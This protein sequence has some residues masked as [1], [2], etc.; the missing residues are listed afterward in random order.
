MREKLQAQVEQLSREAEEKKRIEAENLKL[1]ED[2]A[3][4]ANEKQA[5]LAEVM[6]LRSLSI[7][8]STQLSGSNLSDLGAPT[9]QGKLGSNFGT[10][11]APP[12]EIQKSLS[13]QPPTSCRAE[14]INKDASLQQTAAQLAEASKYSPIA[15]S[16]DRQE[17]NFFDQL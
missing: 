1:K 12:L 16:A 17:A 14:N 6:S 4:L 15:V 11:S 8:S 5:L 3:A 13:D 9:T 7:N 2:L 10:E